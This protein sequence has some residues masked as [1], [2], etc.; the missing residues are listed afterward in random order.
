MDIEWK[1]EVESVTRATAEYSRDLCS[2]AKDRKEKPENSAF[3]EGS[4]LISRFG[5]FDCRILQSRKC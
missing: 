1:E 3:Q 4:I 5:F 2:E